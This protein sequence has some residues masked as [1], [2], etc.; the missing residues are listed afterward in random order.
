MAKLQSVF[1]LSI[2]VVVA[3]LFSGCGGNPR[4]TGQV[5]FDDGTPLTVGEVIFES[6]TVQAR[7]PLDSS[8]KYVMGSAKDK[9]GVPPGQYRVYI[10]AAQVPTGNMISVGQRDTRP[11]M[12]PLIDAKFSQPATSELTCEVKG[13]RKF[14]I[15]VT[16]PPSN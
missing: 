12:R 14:D 1:F 3:G 15:T 5:K 9:D 16:K 13:S 11:E 2:L 6:S 4:V 8:G 10:G 7:G